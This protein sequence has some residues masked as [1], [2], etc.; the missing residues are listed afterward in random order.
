M[1]FVPEK[2]LSV[3]VY[4]P[5]GSRI[6]INE[7][8]RSQP[9]GIDFGCTMTVNPQRNQGSCTITNLSTQARNALQKAVDTSIDYTLVGLPAILA[10]NRPDA[11]TEFELVSAANT[12]TD[13][14]ATIASTQTPQ[15]TI[16][17]ESGK[18]YMTI[19]GGE[20]NAVGRIFEGSVEFIRSA[21]AG[22]DWQTEIQVVDGQAGT[23]AAIEVGFARGSTMFEIVRYIIQAMGLESGNFTRTQLLNAIGNN[24]KSKYA[25]PF[26]I[27]ASGD[28]ILSSLLMLTGANWWVDRGKFYVTRFGQP[29]GDDTVYIEPGR[30][31]LRSTPR[32][33]DRGGIEIETDFNRDMRV[34][35]RVQVSGQG[36]STVALPNVNDPPPGVYRAEQVTHVVNNREGEWSTSAILR[37]IPK[38]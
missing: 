28:G 16:T 36:F 34:G 7:D 26:V 3:T 14:P 29:T 38:I 15:Q 18:A 33:I 24:A 37:P 13:I 10:A 22:A 23:A 30:G 12:G 2:R 17:L 21:P 5:D 35:R 20:D 4:S 19:D 1:A 25:R 8:Q 31:G 6:V 32:Q 27:T 11:P 9:L